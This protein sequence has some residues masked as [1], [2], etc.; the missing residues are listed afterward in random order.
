MSKARDV[1]RCKASKQQTSMVCTCKTRTN[2]ACMYVQAFVVHLNLHFHRQNLG[3]TLVNPKFNFSDMQHNCATQ[4]LLLCFA[5]C[6][7][8]YKNGGCIAIVSEGALEQQDTTNHLYP[9]ISTT[10]QLYAEMRAHQASGNV[11]QN[12]SMQKPTVGG[13]Q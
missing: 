8:F 11:E 10:V 13:Q 9:E 5:T 3:G 2:L 7:S 12:L 4:E 6:P 1:F